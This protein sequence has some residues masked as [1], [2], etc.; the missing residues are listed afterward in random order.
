MDQLYQF[1]LDLTI[2]LQENYPQLLGLMRLLSAMGEEQFYLLVIPAVYWSI[3]KRIG[4]QLAFVFLLSAAINN[5]LKNIFRQPRP[6]WIDPDVQLFPAEG[7]GTPSGHVQHMTAILFLMAF[8]LRRSWIWPL[9]LLFVFLMAFSRVYLGVHFLID[10]AAGFLIG[11]FTLG[12]FLIL[13]HRFLTSYNKRIMGQRMLGMAVIPF[14]L[15]VVYVTLM[16][17]LGPPDL[18]APWAAYIPAAELN[19]HEDV[20]SSVAGLLGFGIGI[21][22]ESSRIRFR[23]DGR[24]WKRILRYLI[25]MAVTLAIWAGL[26]AAFPVEFVW[27]A[28]PLRFIRYLILLFWV[29]YLAPWVFVKLRLATT[30]PEP[31]ARVTL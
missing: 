15:A 4:R 24:V 8:W 30:D 28:L 16:V 9:V 20:V 25:G 18:N 19:G 13:R 11:L 5:T 21:V 3:D 12:F 17:I 6:F 10:T 26:R 31:E 2:W 14:F 1:S 29:S 23:S 27:L 7:Y 22:L